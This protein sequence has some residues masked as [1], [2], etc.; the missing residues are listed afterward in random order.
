MKQ[1]YIA[2]LIGTFILVS[3][4]SLAALSSDGNLLIVAFGFGLALMIALYS[5]GHISGGHF[6]PAV[7]SGNAVGRVP[8]HH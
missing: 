4:G 5:V 6:N 3:I 2:E 7:S 1:S 8:E